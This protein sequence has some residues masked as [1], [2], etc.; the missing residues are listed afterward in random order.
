MYVGVGTCVEVGI[1]LGVGEEVQAAMN[2][3]PKIMKPT[4]DTIIK[5]TLVSADT[6]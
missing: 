6:K 5:S 4:R 1:G 3:T 2:N